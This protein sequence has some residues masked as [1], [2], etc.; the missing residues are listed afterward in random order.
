MFPSSAQQP[1]PIRAAWPLTP[2][3]GLTPTPRRTVE[4]EPK[5]RLALSSFPADAE[6]IPS[7]SILD[8]DSVA[9]SRA[10]RQRG[11]ASGL[12]LGPARGLTP[13]PARTDSLWVTVYGLPAGGMGAALVHFQAAGQ[14][15]THCSE[16]S[17]NWVHIKFADAG[18]AQR[19]L[20]QSGSVI[21]VDGTD[22]MIGVIQA[23]EPASPQTLSGASA[24][25]LR[26]GAPPRRAA[27][28]CERFMLWIMAW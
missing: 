20:S 27:S 4:I 16:G 25:K 26:G 8:L 24:L 14:I 10:P 11:V 6:S 18:A 17:C 1:T 5:S 22:C 13:G 7:A 3:A 15:D 2:G 19:A 12:D 23:C 21:R 28:F 9:P